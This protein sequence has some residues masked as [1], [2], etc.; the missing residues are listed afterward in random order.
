[1]GRVPWLTAALT[2]VIVGVVPFVGGGGPGLTETA[3]ANAVAGSSLF[4]ST[5]TGSMNQSAPVATIS[6][7]ERITEE[8]LVAQRAAQAKTAPTNTETRALE[9][10]AKSK[11]PTVA[12]APA[13]S[14]ATP[15]RVA[16]E[17]AGQFCPGNITGLVS[18][19]P[20][21]SSAQGVAGTTTDDL[22]SFAYAYNSIRVSNCLQPIPLANF[23]Y[24]PC[25]EDR[26]YWMAESP[27]A[28]PLDGWG[29]DGTTRSD[30]VA[31]RGCDG[32]LAGGTDDGGAIVASKW[33]NSE[34]HRESLYRPGDSINGA[35]IAFAMTHGGIDE[36]SN[37]TRAAA[38]W[39]EC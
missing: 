24:L 3:S 27:S 23:L 2:V 30:G 31:A 16:T 29:H 34:A 9:A 20:A 36:P 17:A 26:L 28:D 14:P 5:A 15:S 7:V 8:S 35:C 10:I 38:R 22:A 13:S 39:T 11:A 21:R 33:W 6:G 4:A 32:N 1:M 25:M 12:T 18:S 37:F 19:A